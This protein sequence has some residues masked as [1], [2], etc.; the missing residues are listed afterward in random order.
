VR[1]DDVDLTFTRE[2]DDFREEA[3]TWLTE[4]FPKEPRPRNGP[5]VREYD[6]A[7]QRRQFD[8]GWAGVSWPTEYG[9]RGLPLL[10]QMI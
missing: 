3:R 10:Q 2:E 9:G 4:N 1:S 7:W 5:A 6:L 8:G